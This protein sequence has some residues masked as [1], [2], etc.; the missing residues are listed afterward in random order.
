M[1][2]SKQKSLFSVHLGLD[3]LAEVIDF[4]V[5]YASIFI[6]ESKGI[7]EITAEEAEKNRDVFLFLFSLIKKEMQTLSEDCLNMYNAIGRDSGEK[8]IFKELNKEI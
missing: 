4:L 1:N 6:D 5:N 7:I 3:N 8:I 2:K